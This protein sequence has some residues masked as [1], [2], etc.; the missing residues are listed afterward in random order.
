MNLKQSLASL[1]LVATMVAGVGATAAYADTAPTTNAPSGAKLAQA[2]TRLPQAKD[3]EARAVANLKDRISILTD[4][5]ADLKKPARQARVQ[6]R[7]DKLN[8]RITKL[9]DRLAKAEAK[10]ATVPAT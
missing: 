8:T 10:C 9:G 3:L 6:T 7:I 2:C 1:A 4:L 5:K